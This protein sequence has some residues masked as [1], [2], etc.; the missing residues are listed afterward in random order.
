MSA[1]RPVTVVTGATGGIGPSVCRRASADGSAVAVCHAP[2]EPSRATAAALVDELTAAGGSAVS[3]EADL[4]DPVAIAA[5]TDVVRSALGPA[6]GLVCAAATSVTQQRPWA[7]FD[8]ADWERTLAVNVTGAALTIRAFRD[9]LASAAGSVVVLSS[10]TPLLGRTGNLPYVTS[11]A[12]LIGLVRA[13]AREWGPDGVRVNAIAPGA[14]RTPDE[15][16]YGTEEELEAVLYPL[17]SLRRRGVP[18]DV[19]SA[20]AFLLGADS[21]FVTGQVLVVDGGWVMP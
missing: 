11:K 21:C 18:A 4:A 5:M 17:Q 12:A 16:Y 6:T 20:V 7:E 8:A 15:A 10:V 1:V 13:L 19:A 3:V 2:D 9:D 14:I